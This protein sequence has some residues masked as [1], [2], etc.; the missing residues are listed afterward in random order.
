MSMAASMTQRME[1]AKAAQIADERPLEDLIECVAG[2][3]LIAEDAYADV[4]DALEHDFWADPCHFL[5]RACQA[6]DYEG[7]ER[8]A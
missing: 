5:R 6:A 2:E 3:L 4:V 1:V 7:D 8:R